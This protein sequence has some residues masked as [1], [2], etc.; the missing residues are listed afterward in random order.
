MKKLS[1]YLHLYLGCKCISSEGS[2]T[3]TLWEVNKGKYSTLHKDEHGNEIDLMGDFKLVLRPLSSMT[4]SEAQELYKV[5][6]YSKEMSSI[7]QVELV[8]NVKGY[9]PNIVKISW[10]GPTGSGGYGVGQDIMYLN[11]LESEQHH[12][13]LSKH[14]DLFGL[15]EAGLAIDANLK[16]SI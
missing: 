6:R 11:K 13:L 8:E 10:G 9:Q 7:K 4:P 15:I 1:D 3:Y 12:W 14:F 16:I 5:S 2:M